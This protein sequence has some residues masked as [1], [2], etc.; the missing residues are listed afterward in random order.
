MNHF[1]LPL[2]GGVILGVAAIWLLWALGRVAG[3]SGILWGAGA[4]PE[5][6]WRWAF[7]FGLLGGGLISHQLLGVP[8]P[9][10]QDI[11]TGV[12]AMSGLLVGFGTRLGSGCTS[13]HGVCGLGR[14]SPR[15]LAAV[16]TF[17]ACGV[18]TVLITQHLIGG[19]L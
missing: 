1:T 19:L 16:V 15:S 10:D 7:L 6:P 5:R 14:R 2:I 8:V 12:I 17:I 13:G 3:I 11:S 9:L 18:L 4:G